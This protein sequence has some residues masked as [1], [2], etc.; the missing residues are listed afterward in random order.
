[1]VVSGHLETKSRLSVGLK[2][3][4]GRLFYQFLQNA[5]ATGSCLETGRCNGADG[6][7][8]IPR[9]GSQRQRKSGA[10]LHIVAKRSTNL[11]S[12]ETAYAISVTSASARNRES[13]LTP[14]K[15]QTQMQNYSLQNLTVFSQFGCH[16]T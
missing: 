7:F 1:M 5:R 14:A 11:T 4:N 10:L 2:S 13:A 3:F 8:A 9:N 6:G 15:A 16:R 12:L